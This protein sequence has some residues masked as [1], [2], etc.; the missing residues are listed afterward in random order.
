MAAYRGMWFRNRYF[1]DEHGENYSIKELI[2]DNTFDLDEKEYTLIFHD[3]SKVEL[4]WTEGSES[5]AKHGWYTDREGNHHRVVDVTSERIGIIDEPT[6]AMK[7]TTV[8]LSSGGTVCVSSN[9]S[10]Q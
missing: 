7:V 3:E 2:N 1:I 8:H 6:T 9:L 4:R 5:V 10:L